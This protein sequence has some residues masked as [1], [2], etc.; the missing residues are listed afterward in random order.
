MHLQ[1]AIEP[2]LRRD[3]PPLSRSFRTST[4]EASRLSGSIVSATEAA[5]TLSRA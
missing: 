2:V 3:E 5:S 4:S 1:E